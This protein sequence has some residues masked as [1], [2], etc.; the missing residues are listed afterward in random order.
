MKFLTKS[1]KTENKYDKG[2]V[3][4][5]VYHMLESLGWDLDM[6]VKSQLLWEY[7]FGKHSDGTVVSDMSGKDRQSEIWRRILNNLPYLN[8]HK[9]TKRALSAAL[10]I[11]GVPNSLLTVM[12]F[13]GTKD[14]T[15]S[16]TTKFSFED[17]T[18]SIEISGSETINVPWKKF[19]NDI[20]NE[21]PNSVEIRLNTDQKQ[22]QQI[23][24]ASG[25]SLDIINTNTGSFEVTINNWFYISKFY[26]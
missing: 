5:L 8:K 13:G 21:Y 17:R 10:S 19:N 1:K 3:N 12:E 26:I 9:G 2:I 18:P 25:W 4:E 11:Y 6:G 16:G 20:T 14:P 22:D 24:S 23:I 7:A 15:Q